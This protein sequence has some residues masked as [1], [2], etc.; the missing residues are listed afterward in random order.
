MSILKKFFISKKWNIL[1]GLGFCFASV[2]GGLLWEPLFGLIVISLILWTWEIWGG[3]FGLG[4]KE[5]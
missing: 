1:G 2:L 3:W 4:P 5:P